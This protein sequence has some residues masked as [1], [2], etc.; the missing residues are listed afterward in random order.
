MTTVHG[1]DRATAT[2]TA[3]AMFEAGKALQLQGDGAAGAQAPAA[4]DKLIARFRHSR[5]P[6]VACRVGD[7]LTWGA[8]I[9]MDQGSPERALARYQQTIVMFEGWPD[10]VFRRNLAVAWGGKAI[11]FKKLNRPT[12]RMQALA[13]LARRIDYRPWDLS[14]DE[15][16]VSEE[17]AKAALNY[18]AALQAQGRDQEA[19]ATWHDLTNR[20][21]NDPRPS[22]LEFVAWAAANLGDAYLELRQRDEAAAQWN[23]VVT[24]FAGI[25]HAYLQEQVNRARE[26]LKSLA[27]PRWWPW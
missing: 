1:D 3:T 9:C 22:V 21:G 13:E 26:S 19:M 10:D 12:E 24:R 18:G 27:R 4:Y 16:V 5:D 2:A 17:L 23:Y 7:A 25:D 14:E 6:L 11:A 20:F 8:H 15:T